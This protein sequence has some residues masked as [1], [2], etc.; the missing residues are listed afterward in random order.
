MSGGRPRGG[1]SGGGS[2]SGSP[3]LLSVPGSVSPS[4]SLVLSCPVSPPRLRPPGLGEDVAT[5][6]ALEV[7]PRTLRRLSG[8][9]LAA[10]TP[11]GSPLRPPGV[12]PSAASAPAPPPFPCVQSHLSLAHSHPRFV[13]SAP[14]PPLPA[15]VSVCLSGSPLKLVAS[16][17]VCVRSRRLPAWGTAFPFLAWPPP[18]PPRRP[19]SQTQAETHTRTH[20]RPHFPGI[21]QHPQSLRRDTHTDTHTQSGGSNGGQAATANRGCLDR[22]EDTGSRGRPDAWPD[23][24]RRHRTQVHTIHLGLGGPGGRSGGPMT[25]RQAAQ[26]RYRQ[27]PPSLHRRSAYRHTPPPPASLRHPDIQILTGQMADAR[28]TPG[29]QADPPRRHPPAGHRWPREA[30]GG[31]GRG[32]RRRPRLG[33]AGAGGTHTLAVFSHTHTHSGC[34]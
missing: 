2:S 23:A 17:C 14:P 29:G 8:R 28:E 10:P 21:P 30:A 7:G 24:G 6:V 26:G 3:D 33:G 18:D 25:P 20:A 32:W 16:V 9:P 5:H 11:W 12:P 27:T 31:C 19:H 4:S 13:P 15:S 34:D 1:G 22:Q